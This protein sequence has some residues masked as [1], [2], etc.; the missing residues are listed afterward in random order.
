[1][2]SNYTFA[3]M[4]VKCVIQRVKYA[5]RTWILHAAKARVFFFFCDCSVIIG[6][7]VLAKS[8]KIG[9]SGK[10]REVTQD[11]RGVC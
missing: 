5:I 1:M 11:R 6:R 7:Y 8:T 9:G 2:P 10:V 3:A 4:M